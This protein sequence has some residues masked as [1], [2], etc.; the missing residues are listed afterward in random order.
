MPNHQNLFML[1]H[2]E[3]SHIGISRLVS[4]RELALGFP[5][6]RNV[7]TPK[8]IHAR[9]FRGFTYRD[10]TMGDYKGNFP[11]GFPGC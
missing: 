7:E 9:P 10:F 8:P 2:F 5:G 4:T 6:C 3:V 11:L 1:D